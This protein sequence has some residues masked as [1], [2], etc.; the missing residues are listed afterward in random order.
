MI[1]LNH[2]NDHKYDFTVVKMDGN[3]SMVTMFTVVSPFSFI[4]EP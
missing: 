2:G 3:E 4:L 1:M